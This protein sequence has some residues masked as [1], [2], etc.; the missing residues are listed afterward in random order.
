MAVEAGWHEAADGVVVNR[1]LVASLGVVA[2]VLMVCVAVGWVFAPAGLLVAGC[3][4]V[5]FFL[6]VYDVGGDE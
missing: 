1:P 3:A 5:W 4:C 2:G 6:Q